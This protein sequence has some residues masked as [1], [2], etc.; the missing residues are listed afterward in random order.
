[1]KKIALTNITIAAFLLLSSLMLAQ[2][3]GCGG[4]GGGAEAVRL[5]P[6]FRLLSPTAP[7]IRT[8]SAFT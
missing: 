4:G 5:P 7:H 8:S 1:M 2:M 6:R 3:P